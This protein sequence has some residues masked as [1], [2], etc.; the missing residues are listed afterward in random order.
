M[1]VA[2]NKTQGAIM[3][4]MNTDELYEYILPAIPHQA[5][6]LQATLDK[7]TH[8]HN[9]GE[10]KVFGVS[11]KKGSGKDTLYATYKELID[12]DVHQVQISAGIR[13]EATS[14]LNDLYRNLGEL[15]EMPTLIQQKYGIN[16]DAARSLVLTLS[17]LVLSTPHLTGWDRNNEIIAALQILGS[18]AHPD[19]KYWSRMMT[20]AVVQNTADN[21]SSIVTDLRFPHDA[22]PIHL[23]GGEVIRLNVTPETQAKRLLGR[24]NVVVPE[25]T[26]NHISETALDH[27]TNFDYIIDVDDLEA[28]DVVKSFTS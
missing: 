7:A 6:E 14:I 5:A 27:Y 4:A 11:G 19:E 2:E 3:N 12:E 1:K 15:D 28:V 24:D 10:I 21:F 20:W 23:F 9:T 25:A 26:L 17:P 16:H 8:N 18:I 22:Y 13:S